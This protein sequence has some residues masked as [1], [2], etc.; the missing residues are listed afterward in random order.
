MMAIGILLA[1]TFTVSNF[2]SIRL[3]F[4]YVAEDTRKQIDS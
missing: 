3:S 1:L 2:R 4:S